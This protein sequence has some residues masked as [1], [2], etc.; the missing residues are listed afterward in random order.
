MSWLKLNFNRIQIWKYFASQI[1]NNLV[2]QGNIRIALSFLLRKWYFQ[3]CQFSSFDVIMN[4]TRLTSGDRGCVSCTSTSGRG[5]LV[6]VPACD[7]YRLIASSFWRRRR[8]FSV[9]LASSSS[10]SRGC[11][12]LAFWSWETSSLYIYSGGNIWNNFIKENRGIALRKKDF[13]YIIVILLTLR[14]ATI[15]KWLICLTT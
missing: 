5:E 6:G 2:C 12:D 3:I 9:L 14:E 4:P 1:Y 11:I 15:D 8:S 7:Q 10:K 13:R